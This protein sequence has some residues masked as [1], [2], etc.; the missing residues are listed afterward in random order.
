MTVRTIHT[1]DGR[2]VRVVQAFDANGERWTYRFELAADGT[3]EFQGD[4]DPPDLA[5]VALRGWH[6]GY[7]HA[8]DQ[9]AD[10][11]DGD[12]P[13]AE[14]P[15]GVEIVPGVGARPDSADPPDDRGGGLY[16]GILTEAKLL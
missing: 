3:H 5:V 16:P 12:H 4:G 14:A 13:R 7:D 1:G 10:P 8:P 2:S 11:F 15:P 6:E 9:A